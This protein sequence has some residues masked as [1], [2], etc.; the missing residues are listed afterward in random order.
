MRIT[1]KNLI[2]GLVDQG[3]PTRFIRNL[4]KGHLLGWIS[5]RSHVTYGGKP[6]IK[7]NTKTT[8]QNAAAAMSEKTGVH[9]SNY[10]CLFCDGYHI[11]KNSLNKISNPPPSN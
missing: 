8:A 9:F 7:Y 2:K 5:E 4:V 10:K 3:P 1:F 6:K 11:G